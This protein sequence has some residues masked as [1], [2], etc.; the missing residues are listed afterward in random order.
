MTDSAHAIRRLVRSWIAGNPYAT[1]VNWSVALEPAFRSFS[2]LWAYYLSRE[3]L[4]DA[5]HLD[6]LEGFYDHGRFIEAHLEHYSSPYNHLIGEAAALYMLGAC[7]PE[8][9]DAPRWRATARAVFDRRLAEQ[10]YADGGRSSSRP[11]T[12]TP[13][14]STCWPP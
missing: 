10:F 7:F 4:D 3:A 6:W 13:R 2:W 11:S 9:Q 14:S 8:F 5:F 1:G 12:T